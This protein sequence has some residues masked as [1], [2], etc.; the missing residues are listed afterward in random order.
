MLDDEPRKGD[1]LMVDY[2]GDRSRRVGRRN[3]GALMVFFGSGLILV[4]YGLW[5]WLYVRRA[6]DDEEPLLRSSTRPY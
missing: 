6:P 4:A 3:G 1:T 2:V 5:Y